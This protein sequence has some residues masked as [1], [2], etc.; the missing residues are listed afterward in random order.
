MNDLP[1][2]SL[3]PRLRRVLGD[4]AAITPN[5]R[6]EVEQ[7]LED[8]DIP[9]PEEQ[10]HVLY[11][12]CPCSELHDTTCT[13]VNRRGDGSI[14]ITCPVEVQFG[15]FDVQGERRYL[16]LVHDISER[17]RA[18]EELE[19][20]REH[21]EEQV[22]DLTRDL[23]AA[24]ERAEAADRV[25]STFLATM[26]HELRTPLNSIIGF[27]GILANQLPGPL[28]AEQLKQ[29]EMVRDSA[30]HLLALI[31]DVLDISKIEAG[32]IEVRSEPFGAR[33][34]VEGVVRSVAPLAADKGLELVSEIAD[35]VVQI[36]GDRR[37]FEQVLLNLLSNAVKFTDQGSVRIACG[38]QG[39]W[40]ETRVADTGI[41]IGA[42]DLVHLFE[43]FRQVSTGLDRRYE[44]T[45]LGLSI[46]K[47]LVELMR[48]QI[49]VES[50]A[51]AG[52]TFRFTLPAGPRGGGM[53]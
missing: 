18:E 49:H 47:K 22:P 8:L 45:G 15:C 35:E 23:A 46:S 14:S 19:R 21:L 11:R 44:G 16:G 7:F 42:G 32:Q 6:T 13:Y 30:R 9:A 31:N 4:S 24:K 27:S 37:R 48:G 3:P 5:E 39:E 25:K 26:S 43:P 17:R 12:R 10:G 20:Y 1:R 50:E 52:S 2:D 29:T 34:A 36:T 40:V 38:V 51:G 28:N 41:G 53:P 33:A